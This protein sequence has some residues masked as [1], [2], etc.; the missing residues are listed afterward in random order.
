MQSNFKIPLN[1][2]YIM[3]YV[4][5][6]AEIRKLKNLTQE[7]LARQLKITRST[8]ASYETNRRQINNEILCL[9]ADFYNVTTDYLLGRQDAIPSFLNEDERAII[10]QY[11]I[12]DERGKKSVKTNLSFEVSQAP[13]TENIKKSA[14]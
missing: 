4:S 1:T 12:L 8:Y 10:E 7:D 13:K 3:M 6:L 14:I 11:K 5:R 9:I 2:G